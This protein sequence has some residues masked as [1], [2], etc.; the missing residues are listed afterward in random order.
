MWVC[1]YKSHV[2]NLYLV[3]VAYKE[4]V[5]STQ[6]V[7]HLRQNH[8]QLVVVVDE[9]SQVEGHHNHLGACHHYPR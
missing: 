7:H 4:G 1:E 8:L 6:T 2:F 3:G 9:C 5:W